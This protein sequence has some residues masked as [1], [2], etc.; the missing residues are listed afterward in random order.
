MEP[1]AKP[2]DRQS[3]EIEALKGTVFPLPSDAT[4][5]R[6][7]KIRFLYEAHVSYSTIENTL[8]MNVAPVRH[9]CTYERGKDDGMAWRIETMRRR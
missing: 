2:V 4:T 3:H 6:W 7:V 5:S 9:V 8:P 1:R